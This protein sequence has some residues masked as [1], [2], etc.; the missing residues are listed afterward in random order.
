MNSTT[1][2]PLASPMAPAAATTG[3]ASSDADLEDL[4]YFFDEEPLPLPTDLSHLPAI[5]LQE[6]C[7]RVFQELDHDF[8]RLGAR[9]DYQALLEELQTRSQEPPR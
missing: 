5:E 8:P 2:S 1:V 3:R 7:N 9:D 6:L 4:R